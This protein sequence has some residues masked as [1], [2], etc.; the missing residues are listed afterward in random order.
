MSAGSRSRVVIVGNLTIDLILRGLGSLPSWGQEVE[1]SGRVSAVAGQAGNLALALA[2]L[3]V[4]VEVVGTVGDDDDGRH[5]IAT[6][7]GAGVGT[8]GIEVLAKARTPLSVALV[9]DDGERAFVSDFGASDGIDWEYVGRLGDDVALVCLVGVFNLPGFD[10]GEA[11]AALAAA[12]ARQTRTM[13]DTGWDPGGWP[14]GTRAGIVELLGAVDLFVPNL[15]EAEVLTGRRD[16]AGA[17]AQL[18]AHGPAT[19]VVKCGAQGSFGLEGQWSGTAPSFP[20]E[21]HDAVGAGDSFNA[22]LIAAQLAG[23]GLRESMAYGNALASIYIARRA[24]RFP[25]AAQVRERYE[26]AA[27]PPATTMEG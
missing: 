5:I 6:L 1:A 13:L 20:A 12:R 7:S 25:S 21:V 4:P 11:R 15:D 16:P 10:V 9:R 27:I 24:S 19:V 8:N 26:T 17:A 14:E 18:A 23:D 2:H 22:G 3:E